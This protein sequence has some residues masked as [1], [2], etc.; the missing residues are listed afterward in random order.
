MGLRSRYRKDLEELETSVEHR[1]SKRHLTNTKRFLDGFMPLAVLMIAFLVFTQFLGPLD[2]V[3]IR[4]I[5]YANW[6]LIAFFAV[7]LGIAYR[8]SN[9]HQ[10]FVHRHW[11][12]IMLLIPVFSML[13]EVRA[14]SLVAGEEAPVAEELVASS[15]VANTG[16]AA[17]FTKMARIVKRSVK[18]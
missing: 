9:S 14:F 12:D 15:T 18:L 17:K 4:F 13:Q 8:L 5:N 16:L 7:R 2:P 1:L 6:A 11:L 3:Y 10:D